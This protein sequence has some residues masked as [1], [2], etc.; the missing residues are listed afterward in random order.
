MSPSPQPE[1]QGDVAAHGLFEHLAALAWGWLADARRLELGFSEDTISDLA[2]L[3]IARSGLRHVGVRRVTKQVEG[4]VG[5]DWLWIVSRPGLGPTIYVVQAKKMKLDASQ[6][7][8][9]G[10]LKY[11]AKRKYQI[12]ALEE[13]AACLGAVPLYCFYN[14]VDDHTAI[15]HWHCCMQPPDVAQLGC[16]IVPLDVVRPVHDGSGPKRFHSIHQSQEA[17]PWRCLFHP[18]CKKPGLGN[19]W[20]RQPEA[21]DKPWRARALKFL[22]ASASDDEAAV[23]WQDLVHELGLHHLIATRHSGRS[24]GPL[25]RHGQGSHPRLAPAL[26]RTVGGCAQPSSRP[27]SA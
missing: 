10:R 1:Q 6:S 7:Y 27:L 18:D 16:T 26:A 20:S 17:L 8:S 19:R 11:L 13:F 9:Y 14:H 2:M 23:D 3:E 24:A 21:S 22:A 4:L 5:F 25:L 15:A 12:D